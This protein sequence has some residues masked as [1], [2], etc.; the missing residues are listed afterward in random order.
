MWESLRSPEAYRKVFSAMIR[1]ASFPFDSIGRLQGTNPKFEIF[2]EKIMENVCEAQKL[3][4]VIGKKN[5]STHGKGNNVM[6]G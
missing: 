3:H 4:S 1:R 5:L 6:V 2:S